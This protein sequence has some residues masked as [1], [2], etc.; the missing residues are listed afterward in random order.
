MNTIEYAVKVTESTD[1]RLVGKHDIE[2]KLNGKLHREDGPAIEW[3]SGAT[4]WWKHGKLHRE[5]GPARTWPDGS[6]NYFMF[7]ERHREDGPAVVIPNILQEWWVNGKKHRE[8]G[9]AV[10]NEDG[11]VEWWLDGD[12]LTNAA[13]NDRMASKK[14]KIVELSLSEICKRLGY[15]VSIIRG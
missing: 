3:A 13:F 14:K 10:E 5:D 7:G 8:D 6:V 15:T 12:Q 9:P 2:W 4:E 1:P 11:T